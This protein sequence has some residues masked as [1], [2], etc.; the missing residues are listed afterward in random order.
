MLHEK[1]AMP[2]AAVGLSLLL[3]AHAHTMATPTISIYSVIG[4]PSE[5]NSFTGIGQ[6]EFRYALQNA[7]ASGE[8]SAVVRI[9][10]GGGNWLDAQGIY[11]MIKASAL[12]IDTV[13]DG[14]AASSASIIFMAG[15][16]RMMSAHARLM[17]HECSGRAEG[18][19]ADLEK[20]IEGQR[21]INE[22]MATVYANA[23]G[24]PLDQIRSMMAAETWLS[25][26]EALSLGFATHIINNEK[27]SIAPAAELT[28]SAEHLLQLQ[29]FYADFLPSQPDQMKGLLIPIL[30]AAAVTTITAEATEAQVGAAVQAAF[31]E[32]ATL[33]TTSAEQAEQITALS[34]A[35]DA[36]EAKIKELEQKQI[37]ADAAAA[38]AQVTAVVTAAVKDG[39][40]TAD[41]AEGYTALGMQNLT[42]TTAVLSKLPARAKTLTEQITA[43]AEGG[44]TVVP[45]SAAGAMAEINAKLKA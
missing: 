39:R 21:Q 36:T 11:G 22:S 27:K 4:A 33:R 1:N 43:S 28:A 23:T 44:A 42:A 6:P 41:Q 18:G 15:R 34:S 32:L 7:E 30:Q 12:K 25:A 19:I 10:S 16:K 9:N 17:I 37:D 26:D 29:A 40:I 20:G 5:A 31:D 13:N 38:A 35:K 45:I 14:L 8:S 24:L 3:P 2:S